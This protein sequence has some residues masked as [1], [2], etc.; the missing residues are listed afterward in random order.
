LPAEDNVRFDPIRY[1]SA[2]TQG[3]GTLHKLIGGSV[4]IQV[5]SLGEGNLNRLTLT[6]TI[7]EGRK[8]PRER[9]WIIRRIGEDRYAATLTD[10]VGP[11]SVTVRN[12]SAFINYR[13]KGGLVVDQ[14]LALQPD[15]MI[16]CNRLSV[17]KFGIRVAHVNE[18]IRRLPIGRHEADRCPW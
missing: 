4:R 3:V 12:G 9:A 10:A 17:R 2:P 5:S 15:S 7:R 14:Q 1:F 8:P 11:V 16:V 6:Q 13:M 18:T